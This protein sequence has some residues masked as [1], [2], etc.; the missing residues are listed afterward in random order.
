MRVGEPAADWDGVLRVENVRRRGIV[1]DDRVLQ[2]SPNLRQVLQKLAGVV[3]RKC[4]PCC[5]I[6]SRSCLDGCNNFRG[7]ACGAQHHGYRAGRVEGHR[8]A[9]ISSIQYTRLR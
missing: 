2:V 4:V 3:L 7:I 1:D 8:T 5:G 6:P 9:I